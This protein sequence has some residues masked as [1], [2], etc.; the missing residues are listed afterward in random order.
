MQDLQYSLLIYFASNTNNAVKLVTQVEK[1]AV[2]M[3]TR[4]CTWMAMIVLAS[5]ARHRLLHLVMMHSMSLLG[6]VPVMKGYSYRK[7]DIYV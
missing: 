5:F 7:M 4:G 3:V 1:N 6:R 2:G